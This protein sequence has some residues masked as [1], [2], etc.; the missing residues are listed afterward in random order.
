M[1]S[2]IENFEISNFSFK[3]IQQINE[4]RF[5]TITSQSNYF[6]K[7]VFK[8]YKVISKDIIYYYNK[9][10]KL[11]VEV[12][13]NQYD[14]FVFDFYNNSA[15]VI[16]SILRKTEDIDEQVEKKIKDLCAQFDKK[17]YLND[18]IDRSFSKLYDTQFITKL[19]NNPD[20]LPILNGKK[21]NLKTLELS[22]RI[23]D[24]LFTFECPV[25]FVSK[26]PNADKF[27]KQIQPN[28]ENRELV[29]KV[30]GYLLT[31]DMKARKF[32]IWYGFGS[33]GKSKV[34]KVIEKILGCQ[35]TQLDKSIL[36][37][38]KKSSGAT[39][40][41]MD[42]MG[43]RAGVFSEGETA[44]NI[45]MNIG[46]IKQVSGEDKITG[47]P[48]YCSKVDFY[49]YIKINMLTNF[50]PPLDASK[51]IVD[52]LVYI[53]MDTNF[54]EKPKD[55]NDIKIDNE[56]STKIEN[57]YLSEMFSWIVQGAKEYY[58]QPSIE[59]TE[60]FKKRTNEILSGED[61]IK[62]F[63]DRFLKITKNHKDTHTKLQ[64]FETYRQYCN[65]NSQRCQPR[66]S[67][68]NRLEQLGIKT[69][70][71][72]GYDV[73]YGIQLEL[74]ENEPNRDELTDDD[75][76]KELEKLLN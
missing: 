65:D 52:R 21:I 17:S 18:I 1:N 2:I 43:K 28:K 13:R 57:E 10:S 14:A 53:F 11:W 29:R 16:K 22:D 50:C 64:I 67:L 24:D 48:L 6:A 34:F 63:F 75:L 62:T 12:D 60:E 61:S 41:I 47:R 25:E 44:D 37:K 42:L 31:G 54:T 55:R 40:E 69:R 9:N 39:P 58:K 26:T 74:D 35:Y 19:N 38:S 4:Y 36:M 27:F 72:H 33:N 5:M 73:Y 51:A 46:G 8:Y 7:L 15:S 66:S 45:E 71:L 68:F 3:T 23:P 70:P 20:Y 32:F 59:M 49:P 76:E 30:L 56:F